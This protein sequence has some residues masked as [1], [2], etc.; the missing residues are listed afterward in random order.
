MARVENSYYLLFNC[1]GAGQGGMAW[2]GLAK[3]GM[4]DWVEAGV[5]RHMVWYRAN[6]GDVWGGRNGLGV[7]TDKGRFPAPPLSNIPLLA[8]AAYHGHPQ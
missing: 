2:V 5:A 1:I 7:T 3:D 4:G 8:T 6:I